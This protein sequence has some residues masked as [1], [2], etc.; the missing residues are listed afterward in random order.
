M[1][2]VL[3]DYL[4]RISFS[5]TS[6]E[7]NIELLSQLILDHTRTIP[8]E[9]LNPFL[10]I[11]VKLDIDSLTQ[12]LIYDHRGG[13]CYEQNLLFMQMLKKIGF[14]VEPLVA[15]VNISSSIINPRT[16]MLLIVSIADTQYL[17]DVGFGG[18]TPTAPLDINVSTAQDTPHNSYKIACESGNYQL[19]FLKDSEWHPIYI[20]DF[21]KQQ[22]VDFE[23]SNWFTSTH[24]NSHFINQLMVSRTDKSV[25]YNLRNNVLSFHFNNREVEQVTFT[26]SDEIRNVLK[27]KFGL[28]LGNLPGLDERLSQL[29][30]SSQE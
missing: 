19:L 29:I 28:K 8:F 16:H 5:E 11:P 27:Q 25:R 12:K 3:Q 23:I 2:T 18:I 9:N 6:F 22:S 30:N 10:R 14:E 26:T 24:P 21:Q 15:R 7:P 17:V 1:K 20:F 4:R 13:Y